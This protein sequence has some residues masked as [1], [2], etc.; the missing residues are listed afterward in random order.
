MGQTRF[1][2][3]DIARPIFEQIS[4]PD[5][6]NSGQTLSHEPMKDDL[7]MIPTMSGATAP[8]LVKHREINM[9]KDARTIVVLTAIPHYDYS[10]FLARAEEP[11]SGQ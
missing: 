10:G 5:C 2:F 11:Q 8:F 1:K 4:P 3:D 9:G 6:V 7:V